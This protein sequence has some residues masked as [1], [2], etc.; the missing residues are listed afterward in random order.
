MAATHP[1]PRLVRPEMVAALDKNSK[2]L[3]RLRELGVRTFNERLADGKPFLT[4]GEGAYG[5]RSLVQN[6]FASECSHCGKLGIWVYDKLIWPVHG[7]APDPNSDLS[8]DIKQDYAEASSI[9]GLSPRGAAAL[10]RLAIQKLCIELGGKGDKINDD[11]G[12][13]VKKGLDELVQKALDA[14][15]VIGNSAVHPGQIDLKDDKATAM[16]LFGLVNLIAEIMISR[17]KHVNAMYN[18]LP[19]TALAAIQKRDGNKP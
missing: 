6:L 1:K 14:V 12:M 8:D 16:T 18:A 7:E 4:Q 19:P 3:P 17:P 9:V 11:I 10:L 2:V 13:L 15:R 5:V